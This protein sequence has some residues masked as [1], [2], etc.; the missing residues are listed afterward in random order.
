MIDRKIKVDMS[1]EPPREMS[2]SVMP[3]SGNMPMEPPMMIN[4][5]KMNWK[6]SP[7]QTAW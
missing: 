5:C 7:A 4:A 1:E 2:G 3:V 6:H